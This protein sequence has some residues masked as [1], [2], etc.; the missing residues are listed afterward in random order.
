VDIEAY[1]RTELRIALDGADS[2]RAMPAIPPGVRSILDVGCGAGQTLIASRLDASVRAVGLDP[3]FTAL[4]LGRRMG[5]PVDLV[6]G[7]GESLPFASNS[8]DMVISRVALP[9]MRLRSA[10]GEMSRVLRPGGTLWLLLHSVQHVVHEMLDFLR[11]GQLRPAL[12]RLYVMGNGMLANA[13]GIEIPSP[14]SGSYE[15]FQTPAGMRRQLTRLG[16]DNFTAREGSHFTF[17]AT[18]VR[19]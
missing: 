3:D 9:Y 13:T 5:A 11:A 8:F 17:T 18:K 12:H 2:R 19:A 10:L 14:V 7:R 4:A 1:H 16:F 15:S 6:H